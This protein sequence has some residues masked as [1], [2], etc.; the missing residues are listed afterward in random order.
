MWKGP[1]EV[2]K[3]DLVEVLERLRDVKDDCSCFLRY[4][5]LGRAITSYARKTG[6]RAFFDVPDDAFARGTQTS[7]GVTLRDPHLCLPDRKY[8]GCHLDVEWTT[9]EDNHYSMNPKRV[10]QTI[11]VPV[12]L[13][14]K[15]SRAKFNTWIKG[16]ENERKADREKKERALYKKLHAKYGKKTK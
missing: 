9:P 13:L 10:A 2:A 3:M 4:S 1:D 12:S 8:F 11:Y 15:F 16:L 7:D 6:G 5:D 14:G